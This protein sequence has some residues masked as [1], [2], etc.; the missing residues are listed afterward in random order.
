MSVVT[1][2]AIAVL[3]IAV[4]LLGVAV[5]CN[6]REIEKLYKDLDS[7]VQDLRKRILR[8]KLNQQAQERN[9]QCRSTQSNRRYS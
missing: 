4:M 9:N 7:E 2:T 1:F 5:V 3:S 8:I 6:N